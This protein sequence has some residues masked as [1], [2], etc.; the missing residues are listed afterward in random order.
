MK[1]VG[2]VPFGKALPL[3]AEIVAAH[4]SG[5]LNLA[6]ETLRPMTL[7]PDTFDRKR[8]QFNAV[9]ILRTM[10]K[11]PFDGFHK[12]IGVMDVDLFVPIFTHVFGEARQGGRVALVSLYRLAKQSDGSLPPSSLIFERTAKVALHEVGHLFGLVHCADP[13][14]LMHF[15]GGVEDLDRV[16]LTFCRYCKHFWKDAIR[17]NGP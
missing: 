15:S 6:A 17:A 7:P 13:L 11:L 9:E 16:P 8:L 1:P 4:V 14:C 5:Y 2:V 10:E 3:A 12:V